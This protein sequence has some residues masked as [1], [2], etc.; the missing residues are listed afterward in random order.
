MSARGRF[1][2][3]LVTVVIALAGFATV[4]ALPAAANDSTIQYVALGDS[5]AAG[6]AAGSFPNC[7]QG[8]EGYPELLD[9]EQRIHLRANP[10]CSGATTSSVATTQL[11]ALNR[12]T[13]L[14]TVTVGAADLGLSRVL[15]ACTAVP[16]VDC[17]DA[18]NDAL[19]LLVVGPGGESVLGGRLK[20]LYA[21]IADAAPKALVVVTGYP[22][23]FTPALSDPNLAIK[24]QINAATAAL[25]ATIQQAVA[26]TPG[27]GVDIVYVDV[28][29]TPGF[30][31]HG[32]G[33]TDPFINN[34][35][36][37]NAFHPNAAGYRTYADLISA[38]LP[39]G[40]L[41]GQSQLV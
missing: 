39:S 32:I 12:G 11:S 28:A 6:Q 9:A 40:W 15:T 30:E 26:V 35:P 1:L 18:I 23:L 36:D 4:G 3:G 21:D 20:D 38:V 2:S 31:G 33:G 22:L 5:Y 10:T 24:L 8:S 25:N 17:E 19:A 41:D 29:G 7:M 37:P 34:L 16:P 13:R 27:A 14:V